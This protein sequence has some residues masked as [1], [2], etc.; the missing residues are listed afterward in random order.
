[1]KWANLLNDFRDTFLDTSVEHRV[2]LL[3][4]DAEA[5]IDPALRD[6]VVAFLYDGIEMA[7]AQRDFAEKWSPKIFHENVALEASR[8]IEASTK[9]IEMLENL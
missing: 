1:M 7:K 5:E 9:L 6:T 4:N 8:E 3:I 2:L